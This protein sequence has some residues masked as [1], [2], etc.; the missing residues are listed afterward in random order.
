MKPKHGPKVEE[1]HKTITLHQRKKGK[2]RSNQ[3]FTLEP[4]SWKIQPMTSDA[5]VRMGDDG[6]TGVI[7]SL[8]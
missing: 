3:K 1:K 8:Y 5:A 4:K 2:E 7:V 6:A